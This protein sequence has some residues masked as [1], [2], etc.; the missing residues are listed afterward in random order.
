M[1]ATEITSTPALWETLSEARRKLQERVGF[2]LAKELD[3]IR[4]RQFDTAKYWCVQGEL[5]AEA[6]T[7]VA[8][9]LK[10]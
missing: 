5:A 2:C 1:A 4:I 6:L 10:D 7:S 3:C 8:R 9:V